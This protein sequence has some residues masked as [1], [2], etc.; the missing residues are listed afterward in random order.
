MQVLV[1]D[2]VMDTSC[3]S[4]NADLHGLHIQA[5]SDRLSDADYARVK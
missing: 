2:T 4:R 1:L 3:I 5:L